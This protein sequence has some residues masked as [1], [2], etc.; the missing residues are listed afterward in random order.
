MP[1]DPRRRYFHGAVDVSGLGMNE[2]KVDADGVYRKSIEATPGYVITLRPEA[3]TTK[4]VIGYLPRGVWWGAVAM[5]T[6]VPGGAAT[7]ATIALEESSLGA[8]DGITIA[9]AV[10]IAAAADGQTT[11]AQ[12]APME[13]ERFLSVTLA[14]TLTAAPVISLWVQPTTPEWH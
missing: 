14:G 12:L 10:S 2:P 1:N 4:Q 5:T 6:N 9:S 8:A 3:V 11:T 7:T 13:E